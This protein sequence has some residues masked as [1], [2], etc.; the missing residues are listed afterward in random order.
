MMEGDRSPRRK[1]WPVLIALVLL[2][3]APAAL[4]QMPGYSGSKQSALVWKRMDDCK[5][6]AWKQHPDYTHDGSAQRDAAVKHCLEAS[7]TA[8]PVSP[9]TPSNPQERSGSSR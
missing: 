1:S 9:L 7:N 5:R 6:L 3:V 2:G 4:A 8:P